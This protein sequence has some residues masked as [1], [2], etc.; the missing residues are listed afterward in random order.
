MTLIFRSKWLTNE[1]LYKLLQLQTVRLSLDYLF[2]T[3]AVTGLPKL[4][5]SDFSHFRET[6]AVV[7]LT[8]RNFSTLPYREL[9]I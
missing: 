3:S 5:L 7:S 2:Q 8:D 6:A 4:N 1:I 9:R